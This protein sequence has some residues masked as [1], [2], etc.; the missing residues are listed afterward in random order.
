MRA[1]DAD[2]TIAGLAPLERSATADHVGK[3]AML[4]PMAKAF[5][6]ARR[7]AGLSH[8]ALD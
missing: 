4:E 2:A 5:D 7:E 3:P 8:L 6:E 1:L